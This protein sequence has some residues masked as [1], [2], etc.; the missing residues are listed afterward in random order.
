[1]KSKVDLV[2]DIVVPWSLYGAFIGAL[3]GL[4]VGWGL[5]DA[6]NEGVILPLSILPALF[7]GTLVGY[8][9]SAKEVEAKLRQRAMHERKMWAERKAKRH[10]E[11]E[12]E[13][14]RAFAELEIS[15]QLD[16]GPFEPAQLIPGRLGHA[17]RDHNDRRGHP[18]LPSNAQWAVGRDHIDPADGSKPLSSKNA[19]EQPSFW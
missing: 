12:L 9:F 13:R 19:A 17:D 16:D 2:Q 4:G 1:M 8:H 7:V 3:V 11:I 6:F 10:A 18:V 15:G 14:K 5:A